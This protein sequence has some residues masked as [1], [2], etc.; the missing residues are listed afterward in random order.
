[1]SLSGD[2][3]TWRSQTGLIKATDGF[4]LRSRRDLF[5]GTTPWTKG[6]STGTTEHCS[7]VQKGWGKS[8]LVAAIAA[9][10]L[11]GPVVF[12]HFDDQ[13]RPVGRPHPNPRVQLAAIS[14]AQVENTFEPL[15]EMLAYGNASAEYDLDIMLSRIDRCGFYSGVIERVTSSFRSREGN[16]PTFV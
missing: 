14:E 6:D 13:G 7:V 3:T 9:T 15:R 5:Y 4:T 11:L 12:S 8:P 1:M 10:E 2:P 16:R